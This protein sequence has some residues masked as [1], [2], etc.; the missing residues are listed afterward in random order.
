MVLLVVPVYTDTIFLGS[1]DVHSI[2]RRGEMIYYEEQE[3][4]YEGIIDY[5][6]FIRVDRL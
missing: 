3:K 6:A 5:H 4:N 1:G 2:I